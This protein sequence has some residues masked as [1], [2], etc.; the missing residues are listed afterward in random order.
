MT[1]PLLGEVL[2]SVLKELVKDLYRTVS[3][4]RQRKA[5][6]QRVDTACREYQD[7]IAKRCQFV[8]MWKMKEAM[9]LAQLYVR[10]DL[11]DSV[12]SKRG[13][14]LADLRSRS[15]DAQQEGDL[16]AGSQVVGI[17]QRI[18]ILG[19]PG[20][21]KTTFLRSVVNDVV[22]GEL[23][24]GVVPFYVSA[25][26]LADSGLGTLQ[27]LQV[28]LDAC[29]MPDSARILDGILAAGN[30]MIVVDGLDEV[31]RHERLV[32]IVEDLGRLIERYPSCRYIASCRDSAYD[33]W[34]DSFS[35]FEVPAFTKPQVEEFAQ[36]WFGN[37]ELESRFLAELLGRKEARDFATSPLLLTL[38]CACFEE[39]LDFPPNKA[40]LYKEAL[41]GLLVRWDASR[42]VTRATAYRDLAKSR[43]GLLFSEIARRG[44]QLRQDVWPKS[45]IEALIEAHMHTRGTGNPATPV[46]GSAI[47][48]AIE[49]QHGV[50][51][52]LSADTVAFSHASFRDYYAAT[53]I[54]ERA[55]LDGLDTVL[56]SNLIDERW[57]DVILLTIA[58]L[59]DAD[60]PM[61]GLLQAAKHHMASLQID[62][63]LRRI[64]RNGRITTPLTPILTRAVGFLC[65]LHQV[66]PHA[67]AVDAS[68]A[69]LTG[70]P[71]GRAGLLLN[72]LE[73][74]A[75]IELPSET[76]IES[77]ESVQ[78]IVERFS[79]L[80]SLSHQSM[81]QYVASRMGG[82]YV[83]S[84]TFAR[85]SIDQEGATVLPEWSAIVEL[86]AKLRTALRLSGLMLDCVRA[87][88]NLTRDVRQAV[89]E[90]G[91]PPSLMAIVEQ[92]ERESEA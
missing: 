88:A 15:L 11:R 62:D 20:S 46:D 36:R 73:R 47:L 51:V 8:R 32:Q 92:V 58:L 39:T 23:L 66:A 14:S 79:R 77:G 40:D 42:L 59:A 57:R 22:S 6:W 33:G 44:L 75:R 4:L 43:K 27:Y 18:V 5:D 90:F 78:Q 24:R 54:V 3:S 60:K 30:G 13:L 86:G 70:V 67:H 25:K 65:V 53:N 17:E 45:E 80:G 1:D 84:S 72:R 52:S 34:F 41:E 7:R 76:I 48:L 55:H 89:I 64:A 21:G 28:E 68:I 85:V 69:A 82:A 19:R 83:D 37:P 26:S 56:A 50:L 2:S 10:I 35:V 87:G 16:R 61:L 81:N 12:Q 49:Q 63:T 91:V 74:A 71:S 29:N 9:P 38:M 31:S